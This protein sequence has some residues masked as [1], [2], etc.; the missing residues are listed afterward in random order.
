[1]LSA[2]TTVITAIGG[3]TIEVVTVVGAYVF[4]VSGGLAAVRARLDLFG[5]MVLAA[6]VGLAGGILRDV[7]LGERATAFFDWRVVLA[8][9]L[10]GLTAFA[11]GRPLTRW[12]LSIDLFDAVGLSLFCVIGTDLALQQHT[13]PVPAVILGAVTAIGGGVVRDVLLRVVPEVL[14]QGL[15]AIPALV[16]SAI[17]VIGFELGFDN[18][19]W[20]A[21]GAGVCLIIR[22]IGIV[23]RINLPVA[24]VPTPDG[25]DPAPDAPHDA[26]HPDGT[27]A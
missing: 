14:R 24:T 17:I 12:Q 15:Y 8:V 19:A 5:V 1:M 25:D 7:L 22:V 13:G 10:A 27:G 2:T 21:L 11:F 26:A 9:V 6:M 16:G 3:H 20:Y 18:L 23:F 4:G